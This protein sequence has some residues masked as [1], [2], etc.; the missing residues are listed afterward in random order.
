MH[1]TSDT[2]WMRQVERAADE[3]KRGRAV[4]LTHDGQSLLVMALE[5]VRQ[6]EAAPAQAER[7]GRVILAAST[8]AQLGYRVTAG[9]LTVAF[10]IP[11][12]DQVCALGLLA[13]D[14]GADVAEALP[15]SD[16]EEAARRLVRL[17]GLAPAALLAPPVPADETD[18]MLEVSVSDIM[19][20]QRLKPG[21]ERVT[22]QPVALPLD[23]RE[24]TRVIAFRD[25]LTQATHLLLLLGDPLALEAPPVRLHSSCLTGDVLGSLRCECGDQ[26]HG[27]LALLAQEKAGI[28]IYLNQ[29]G[30]GIGLVNKLRAYGLQDKGL[31]TVDANIMLGFEPDER[32][33]SLAAQ[34]LRSLGIAS[35]RLLTNNPAKIDALSAEKIMVKE[36]IPLQIQAGEHN[37][38]YL[39]AKAKRLRHLL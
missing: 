9:M 32:D 20:Y 23:V 3:L 14:P 28:L 25:T 26:L 29:E 33:F 5:H 34:M 1:Y 12:I 10:T 27:A 21:L 17:S 16:A 37:H 30:R 22:P 7:T 15:A 38:A 39:A 35:V 2:F 24:D 8:A 31:D 13:P 6:V 19:R 18:S 11:V 36:R 4:H